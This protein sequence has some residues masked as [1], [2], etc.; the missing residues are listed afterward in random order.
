MTHAPFVCVW[1]DGD[2]QD[3]VDYYAVIF[4]DVAVEMHGVSALLRIHGRQVML[5]AGD[6]RYAPNPAISFM[7]HFDAELLGGAEE[8]S[9]YFDACYAELGVGGE[10]MPLGE[11]PFSPRYAWVRDRFGVN[12]QLF[13]PLEAVDEVVV[14]AFMFG[15]VNHL[16]AEP[17][18][19]AWMQGL[20]GE[21][22]SLDR[23]LDAAS[24]AGVEPE[25]VMFS[26]FTLRGESFIAMDSGAYHD[27]TFEPGVSLVL[28]CEDQAEIDEAWGLLSKRPEAERCGWC[29][30]A[31]GVS[32]QVVPVNMG[33][34][35]AVP[36]N[37]DKLL[38]M[39]KIEL[40]QL[41]S[42]GA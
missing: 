27:F 7:V 1:I 11:Y 36:G 16:H 21:R 41:Q 14:P 6:D 38:A 15:G 24:A 39:G 20:G 28:L 26:R 31:W 34:L 13:T 19:D 8:A 18:T 35:F 4:R 9:A 29:Q 10:L 40:S 25:A 3:A 33:E 32:W 30:D 22:V 42:A 12:W 37:V 17:A 23:Y 5:L 2:L